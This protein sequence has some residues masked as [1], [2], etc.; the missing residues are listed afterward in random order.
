MFLKLGHS[1]QFFFL[2]VPSQ[3]LKCKSKDRK[4]VIRLVRTSL[5]P[6]THSVLWGIPHKYIFPFF[7]Y[8][9]LIFF[10]LLS[11]HRLWCMLL[12]QLGEN[13]SINFCELSIDLG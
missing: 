11:F 10:I 6:S 5:L 12:I 4:I 3:A 9:I 8:F 13:K 2:I 1:V 7:C